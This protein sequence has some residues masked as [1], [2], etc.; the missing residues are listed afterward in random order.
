M[1]IHWNCIPEIVHSR[2]SLSLGLVYQSMWLAFV[3]PCTIV[4]SPEYIQFGSTIVCVWLLPWHGIMAIRNTMFPIHIRGA[5]NKQTPLNKCLLCC[6]CCCHE[7]CSHFIFRVY[8][9]Q[10]KIIDFSRF[11]FFFFYSLSRFECVYISYFFSLTHTQP[12]INLLGRKYLFP[13]FLY[14]AHKRIYFCLH[15]LFAGQIKFLKHCIE[16]VDAAHQRFF[17][18]FLSPTVDLAKKNVAN[19]AHSQH[20]RAALADFLALPAY[21]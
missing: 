12:F 2:I 11:V 18:R 21:P 8:T 4:H 1:C 13:F 3:A 6:C 16:F 9:N 10:M 17:I 7:M 20:Y 19:F 5:R 14:F 15:R